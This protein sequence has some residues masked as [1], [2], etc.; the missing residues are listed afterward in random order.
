MDLSVSGRGFS[1]NDAVRHAI[2]QRL[3]QSLKNFGSDIRR[4]DVR[5]SEMPG[6][7][8]EEDKRC[9]MEVHLT[10][11]GSLWVREE[12]RLFTPIIHRAASRVSRVLAKEHARKRSSMRP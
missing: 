7:K 10:Q 5:L 1:V 12:G 6:E 11:G 9:Q 4:V 2:R 8:G 3:D